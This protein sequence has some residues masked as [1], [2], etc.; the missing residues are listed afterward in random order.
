MG[1]DLSKV[2][3][4]EIHLENELA[5]FEPRDEVAGHVLI[6]AEEDTAIHSCVIWL[7]GFVKT[8]WM[9]ESK[10]SLA[11]AGSLSVGL[12]MVR[13]TTALNAQNDKRNLENLCEST[14]SFLNQVTESIRNVSREWNKDGLCTRS[15]KR[16]CYPELDYPRGIGPPLEQ[17]TPARTTYFRDALSRHTERSNSCNSV[18]D[19]LV[20]SLERGS[21]SRQ[22]S[23]TS[24]I[25]CISADAALEAQMKLNRFS[26]LTCRSCDSCASRLANQRC[27]VL[28]NTNPK[29]K[30]NINSGDA[31]IIYRAK[32]NLLKHY[33]SPVRQNVGAEAGP[34]SESSFS[35][36]QD[37][38]E[39]KRID[40]VNG[41]GSA[42]GESKN[43][44][45]E[46]GSAATPDTAMNVLQKSSS[47]TAFLLTRGTHIF[48]FEFKLPADLPSSF[49]LPTS[50]LA[51]GAAAR[52]CYGLRIE[53]RNYTA[54][55]RHTQLRE[56][57]VFR[58]LELTHFPRLRDRVTLH[59]EFVLSG[60]CAS[61]NG[62]ILC[63]LTVNKT[64]FVPGESIIPQIYIVNRSPRAI[65]T[66]HLT[67]AQT[68]LLRGR[69]EQRHVEVLR[70]FAARLKPRQ[71]VGTDN[72]TSRLA[73]RSLE[74]NP[75]LFSPSISPS[76]HTSP[77]K[78]DRSRPAAS[79]DKIGISGKITGELRRSSVSNSVAV[80]PHGASAYFE[81]I[82]HVPPLPATGLFGRQNL[83][84]VE[85]ML[86]LRLRIEGD[87]EGK[88]EQRMQIPITVGS[89]PTR[90]TSFIGSNEVVPCYASFNY[91]SGEVTEYDPSAHGPPNQ[92]SR[93]L[94][95]VY[96][97]FKPRTT[98][99]ATT[100][101]NTGPQPM[102]SSRS[103][104]V[105][106]DQKNVGDSKSSDM[107]PDAID[108]S[109]SIVYDRR[110]A[111]G[112]YSSIPSYTKPLARFTL[113]SCTDNEIN[114]DFLR[115]RR[116][117]NE[118]S[119]EDSGSSDSPSFPILSRQ[120]FFDNGDQ[121]TLNDDERELDGELSNGAHLSVESNELNHDQLSLGSM[122]RD[123]A[124]SNLWSRSARTCRQYSFELCSD[125]TASGDA[126]SLSANGL[127]ESDTYLP[128]KNPVNFTRTRGLSG[129]SSISDS[130]EAA[131]F[132]LCDKTGQNQSPN[133]R[134]DRKYSP[135][136]STHSGPSIL[137]KFIGTHP[138][139]QLNQVLRFESVPRARNTGE[140]SP[141][142]A[143]GS[144]L[145]S[146]AG[147]RPSGRALHDAY[148]SRPKVA[149]VPGR[150]TGQN[151][152]WT[153]GNSYK[154]S[155]Q[156]CFEPVEFSMLTAP[157][158]QTDQTLGDM[159][160]NS[161]S[162]KKSLN[163]EDGLTVD[164]NE[165]KQQG[166]QAYSSKSHRNTLV[167]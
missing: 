24:K 113:P 36:S 29:E 85:Y 69:R 73:D 20:A 34:S 53:I 155:E 88:H 137:R 162:T 114:A 101:T 41:E 110:A 44:N 119:T 84:Q 118:R 9:T 95:P 25:S 33:N 3:N 12:N 74:E 79:T 166:Y 67:F 43:Q 92:A 112:S 77:S 140:E 13:S 31:R 6:R 47:G 60:C 63:D 23:S 87:I 165:R 121:I 145:E 132:D 72:L 59:K 149:P 5:V 54:K 17:A 99:T 143:Q 123:E 64:G 160:Q 148:W 107:A 93:H 150:E 104:L 144:I 11:Q 159:G 131:N 30:R 21:C 128:D 61:P 65:H 38:V 40:P 167:G 45:A 28:Q 139:P 70:L 133:H 124:H 105:K 125:H 129:G 62:L 135:Q 57:I 37:N 19:T 16:Q 48:D 15:F 161:Q 147:R 111:G 22:S 80:Q 136:H 56:I 142:P 71:S 109:S 98:I 127:A 157:K 158:S 75:S 126:D 81:D 146:V 152:F 42:D 14:A 164:M 94:R 46:F 134:E 130:E 154:G 91:A 82:I 68:I 8:R 102:E 116:E 96:R 32:V 51:G 55:I 2:Y 108:Y 66:V 58:P 49:E 156:Q 1:C 78:S 76:S 35:N 122:F 115:Q 39:E 7:Y 18:A 27:T 120:Q 100:S 103:S 163:S 86:V 4:I 106:S 89:D 50:C 52:L 90:E 10:A 153:A 26:F 117:P 97:Y 151:Q 83:I 141:V 138:D